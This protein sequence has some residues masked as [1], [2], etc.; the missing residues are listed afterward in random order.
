MASIS[1]A[2]QDDAK[3]TAQIVTDAVVWAQAEAPT[4]KAPGQKREF[5]VEQAERAVV[6]SAVL[7]VRH[8]DAKEQPDT[9]AW[10]VSALRQAMAEP[11]EEAYRAPQVEYDT[12]AIAA[13]GLMTLYEKT[14]DPVLRPDLLKLA[15]SHH[16]S[17]ANALAG[18]FDW[19]RANDQRFLRSMFRVLLLT[20]SYVRERYDGKAEK[21][22]AERAAVEERGIA[23]ELAWL[24]SDESEP[25]WPEIPPWRL[26]PKRRMKIPGPCSEERK[27]RRSARPPELYA[28]ESRLGLISSQLFPLALGD[29]PVWLLDLTKH[30]AAW[31]IE[32]N[33]PDDDGGDADGRPFTFN[34]H[35]FEYLGLLVAAFP[36]GEAMTAFIEPI[37]A[38]PDEACVDVIAMLLRGFDIAVNSTDATKPQDVFVLRRVLAA[39]IQQTRGYRH[40]KWEKSFDC[41]M[42]LGDV[43]CAIFYQ[44]PRGFRLG[45]PPPPRPPGDFVPVLPVLTGLVTSAPTSGYIAVLF[46]DLMELSQKPA[47]LP[48]VLEAL[49]GWCNAYGADTSFWGNNDVGARTCAWLTKAL[50]VEDASLTAKQQSDLR[51]ALDI[52]VRAGARGSHRHASPPGE[53]VLRRLICAFRQRKQSVR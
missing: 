36:H 9:I 5:E 50:S 12:K 15:T 18:G 23:A 21:P 25:A 33:G 6:M 40:F 43:L 52:L 41:E 14:S 11:D 4:V 17:V 39:R 26:R 16:E 51:A 38:L 45:P 34:R 49:M 3:V 13:A 46:L 30:L 47:M 27:P 1:L 2:F 7:S 48:F 20:S 31:A 53:G 10:A 19:L 44:R 8:I 37:L 42:H 29:R 28:D 32:A 24:E 22:L 35:F